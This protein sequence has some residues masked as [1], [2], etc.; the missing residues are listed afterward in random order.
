MGSPIPQA[1]LHAADVSIISQ[2]V[3]LE[4][5]SRDMQRWQR[6]RGCYHAHS[7]VRFEWCSGSGDEYVDASIEMARKGV[8][9]QHRLGPPLVRIKQGRAVASVS[10][11]LSIPEKL[12]NTEVRVQA[13]SLLMYRIEKRDGRWAITYL[14]PIY[15]HDEMVSALPGAPL[16]QLPDE[17]AQHRASYRMLS[18]FM[19]LKGYQVSSEIAGFD[20][21][22]TVTRLNAEV[23]S[24]ADIEP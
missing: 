2:L 17:I 12:G 14:D 1:V 18:Y 4:R 6:L 5:E 23:F 13:Y 9:A 7:R 21:P 11:I 19:A 24:W 3:L 15:L 10:A 22:E 20:K 16:P 8:Q